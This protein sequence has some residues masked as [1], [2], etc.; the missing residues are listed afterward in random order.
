MLSGLSGKLCYRACL[1]DVLGHPIGLSGYRANCAIGAIGKTSLSGLSGNPCYR[2]YREIRAI[3]AIGKT[4]LSG[5]S[6][7]LCYR[8]ASHFVGNL[9]SN[10]ATASFLIA[11]DAIPHILRQ[12]PDSTIF[13]IGLQRQT[14]QQPDSLIACTRRATYSCSAIGL[15]GSLIA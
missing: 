10:D 2:G 9:I 11:T 5:L 13:L 15:S 6:G 4:A 1:H 14:H 12:F 7:K 8:A 3:G